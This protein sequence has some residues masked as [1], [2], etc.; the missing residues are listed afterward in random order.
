[1]DSICSASSGMGLSLSGSCIEC[2][3]EDECGVIQ[4]D[5]EYSGPAGEGGYIP[6]TVGCRGSVTD[7]ARLHRARQRVPGAKRS[8][9]RSQVGSCSK[10]VLLLLLLLLMLLLLVMHMRMVRLQV[11]VQLELLLER[12]ARFRLEDGRLADGLQGRIPTGRPVP[13]LAHLAVRQ[14]RQDLRLLRDLRRLGLPAGR[15]RTPTLH[16]E[17][18]GHVVGY[19]VVVAGGGATAGRIETRATVRRAGQRLQQQTVERVHPELA[20]LQLAH[21]DLVLR[22]VRLILHLQLGRLLLQQVQ[23]EHALRLARFV[24]PLA[25]ERDRRV[26]RV[27]RRVHQPLR[28]EPVARPA[29]L[30]GKMVRISRSAHFVSVFA[31]LPKIDRRPGNTPMVPIVHVLVHRVGA[32][33]RAD[34]LVR[35]G[36]HALRLIDARRTSDGTEP[37]LSY[38][39]VVAVQDGRLPASSAQSDRLRSKLSKVEKL[40]RDESQLRFWLRLFGWMLVT[41]PLDEL[42][43]AN[44]LSR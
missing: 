22:H 25:V 18:Q 15:P 44:E 26:E 21:V 34:H 24:Q 43:L 9:V 10:P 37:T 17:R 7:L 8:P 23:L 33:E 20:V 38:A 13:R 12:L 14:R 6:R 4:C 36:V 42:E 3:I 27:V 30:A 1:M 16:A 35:H 32:Q 11:R 41:T 28:H 19:L 29:A 31:R 2:W 39:S 5:G 40:L